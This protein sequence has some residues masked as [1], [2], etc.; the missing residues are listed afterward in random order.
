MTELEKLAD[1]ARKA[2]REIAGLTEEKKNSALR[3]V[4]DALRASAQEILAANAEDMAAAE[5]SGMSP[6]MLDRLKLTPE[7]IESMADGM[8]QVADLPDPTGKVLGRTVRPN[9]LVIEKVSVPLGVVGIIYEAR[10]NVTAD[11]AALCFK[12]GNAVLLRGGKEAVRSGAA[13]SSVMRAAL[14]RQGIPADCIC[15]VEDTTRESA[16]EMMGLVGR[17]DVLI[18]RGGAGLIR[19]VVENSRVPV[20]ETGVG[21]C[22]VY[23]EKTADL[24][25]AASIIR[26]AKCSRPSVC[27]AAECLIVDECIAQEFLPMAAAAMKDCG[28]QIRGDGKTCSVLPEAVPASAQ[29]YDTEFLDYILAVRTVPGPDEAMEFI[30]QHGTGHS[31]AIVT[32]D[33]A[34]ADRFLRR[35]DAA[36]VYVN[37]STRFTDGGEFGLGAELGIS[38]Q[39]LHARGPMG[40][41]ELTSTKYMIRG[42]GQIR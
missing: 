15:F 31:E 40:L 38:T 9:G 19:S 28:V 3:A 35:V 37:A 41:A 21:I 26:N 8:D 16:K 39:K 14:D 32:R 2:S 30:A 34:V 12:S 29:D 1:R 17:L 27:N 22:H 20:I 13:I 24:G 18:P 5:R 25:M 36:A 7:R 6:A 10:P 23:V 33:E 42:T 11:A 4:S